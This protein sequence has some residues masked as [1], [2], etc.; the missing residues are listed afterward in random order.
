MART[1]DP[2]AATVKAWETRGR[3]LPGTGSSPTQIRDAVY[4]REQWDGRERSFQGALADRDVR[5]FTKEWFGREMSQEDVADLAG[6]PPGSEVNIDYSQGDDGSLS[7][8]TTF[9]EGAGDSYRSIDL[10]TKTIYNLDMGV[11]SGRRGQGIGASV[12]EMEVESGVKQGFVRIAVMA[13]GKPNTGVSGYNAWARLGFE[14]DEPVKG[15]DGPI[16]LNALMSQPG[17]AAWWRANGHSFGGT[18]SLRP[19][20]AS[21]R[22]FEE[23]RR[24]KREASRGAALKHLRPGQEWQA[25]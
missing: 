15:P 6:A 17:G 3:A 1:S 10:P 24:L 16:G 7:V 25:G 8:R 23:Y 20:S 13:V 2:H 11:Q 19:G 12:L 14:S 5:Q 9:P 18:F 21:M 22:V 4:R